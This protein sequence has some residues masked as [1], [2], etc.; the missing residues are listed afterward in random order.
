MF[1]RDNRVSHIISPFLRARVDAAIGRVIL[2]PYHCIRT[3]CSEGESK[4]DA[5]KDYFSSAK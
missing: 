3:F 5:V 2:K 4:K 1:P